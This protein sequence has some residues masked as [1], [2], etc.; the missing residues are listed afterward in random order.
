MIASDLLISDYS[1]IFFDYAILKR[2][3]LCFDYDY[4]RYEKERGMYFDIRGY[5]P[6]ANNEDEMLE[7]IKSE[8]SSMDSVSTVV[9]LKKYVTAF[10]SASKKSLNI[11][12][13]NI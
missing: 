6:H 4:D 10:G 2:P 3:M 1:S 13:E 9:F 11:I 8:S 12:Y 7:L 5:L